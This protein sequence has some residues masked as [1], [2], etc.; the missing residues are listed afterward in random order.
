[1]ESTT[2][3]DLMIAVIKHL[4]NFLY[5]FRWEGELDGKLGN[6]PSLVVDECDE[7]GEPMTEP[8]EEEDDE[9]DAL[10]PAGF[11]LPPTVPPHL[12]PQDEIPESPEQQAVIEKKFEIDLSQTQQK[13]YKQFQPP[14]GAS[15]KILFINFHYSNFLLFPFMLSVNVICESK[16]V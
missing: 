7:N 10:P 12:I 14:T 6:F 15:I 13:Q 8:E 11:G 2:D 1:M 5:N 9:D 4:S 3:G 16:E